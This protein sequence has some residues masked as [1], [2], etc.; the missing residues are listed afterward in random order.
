MSK[1][2]TIRRADVASSLCNNFHH[3][4]IGLKRDDEFRTSTNFIFEDTEDIQNDLASVKKV[5]GIKDDAPHKSYHFH[6]GGYKKNT[7]VEGKHDAE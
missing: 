4:I 1:T 5:L 6:R 2:I 7:I 3:P